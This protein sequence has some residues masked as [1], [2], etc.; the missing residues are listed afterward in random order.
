MKLCS[1]KKIFPPCDLDWAIPADLFS[2]PWGSFSYLWLFSFDES[3]KNDFFLVPKFAFYSLLL[4]SFFLGV[5]FFFLIFFT[6]NKRKAFLSIK[7]IS[8]V[9]FARASVGCLSLVCDDDV[10]MVSF[11]LSHVRLYPGDLGC[12]KERWLLAAP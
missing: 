6:I 5:F 3:F 1:F 11:M 4:D 10:S 9:I 12:S 2:N 7:S 8:G